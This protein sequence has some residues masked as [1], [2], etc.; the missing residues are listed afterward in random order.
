VNER[1]EDFLQHDA[2]CKLYPAAAGLRAAVQRRME[3]QGFYE[4]RTLTNQALS[5]LMVFSTSLSYKS[6]HNALF[7]FQPL[8]LPNLAPKNQQKL[9]SCPE[10]PLTQL[11]VI[12][13]LC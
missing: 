1:K 2:T 3:H 8:Q 9:H 6:P 13:F 12:N 7:S 11:A 10:I 5:R 4:E